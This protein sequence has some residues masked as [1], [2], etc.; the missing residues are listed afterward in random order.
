MERR[1]FCRMA[2]VCAFAAGCSGL[3]GCARLLD[4][5]ESRRAA[6]QAR[7]FRPGQTASSESSTATSPASPATEAPAPPPA[8]P[9]LAVWRGENAEANVRAAIDA[10]GGMERFVKRGARVAIKPNI[11][12]ARAPEYAVTTNPVVMATLVRLAF[13]AGAAD[14]VSFDRPTSTPRN[15]YEVSGIAR[16]VESAGGRMKVLTDRDFERI[17]IPDGQALTSWPFAVPAFEADVLINV[18]IAKTHGATGLTLAGKNMMGATNDRG[19]MHTLGLSRS[20]AEI[21]R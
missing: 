17:A 7:E 10:L 18:P 9:D 11:L 16:A 15:A 14:V 2:A 6:P 5:S 20:I 1:E 12:T 13:E 21:N 3:T 19:T 4:W 8:L